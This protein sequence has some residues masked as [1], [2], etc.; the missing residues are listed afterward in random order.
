[1]KYVL[2]GLLLYLP[3]CKTLINDDF[4]I[5][6]EKLKYVS[7]VQVKNKQ[8][9]AVLF[10]EDP[11]FEMGDDQMMESSRIIVSE[12][13]GVLSSDFTNRLL[14]VE[15][16][17]DDVGNDNFNLRLSLRRASN[18]AKEIVRHGYHIDRIDVK[19]YGSQ[20]PECNNSTSDGRACNRRVQIVIF[21]NVEG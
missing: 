5:L 19:G 7:G 9:L 13:A 4:V 18:V 6:D 1:M 14:Y 3:A 2:L 11:M 8:G 21:K 17:T 16:H 20:Y 12:V 10:F 15:G